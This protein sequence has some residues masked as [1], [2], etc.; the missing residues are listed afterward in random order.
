MGA[1]QFVTSDEENIPRRSITF[2][3]DDDGAHWQRLEPLDGLSLSLAGSLVVGSL[4]R[5][6][7]VTARLASGPLR[8]VM[9]PA[10][11]CN[12]PTAAHLGRE[13]ALDGRRWIGWQD[14]KAYEG[15]DL[16]TRDC[17]D[18]TLAE[19][20]TLWETD[21]TGRRAARRRAVFRECSGPGPVGASPRGGIVVATCF[22]KATQES[23]VLASRH[24]GEAFR[25]EAQ[26]HGM[27]GS[28]LPG[29]VPSRVR[30]ASDGAV[31]VLGATL[32]SDSPGR[33]D[34]WVLGTPNGRYTEVTMENA[35][36]GLTVRDV[37][38]T[39]RGIVAIAGIDKSRTS[40][41]RV[42]SNGG[43]TWTRPQGVP[44]DL[45]LSAVAGERDDVAVFG[46]RPHKW[47]VG[48]PPDPPEYPEG[49]LATVV[50]IS[51]DGGT[52]WHEEDAPQERNGTLAS[53]AISLFGRRG[54][55]LTSE[56]IFETTDAAHTWSRLVGSP[57]LRPLPF[58]CGRSGCRMS[59][60]LA[61]VW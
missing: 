55:A 2:G 48:G 10:P 12:E 26:L 13:G 50:L 17:P 32:S 58:V 28:E 8:W 60:T 27:S 16:R 47:L 49:P 25:E 21:L 31:A 22:V 51:S 33:S 30:V 54:L 59:E 7:E 42:S 4:E 44:S 41:L 9:E 45:D 46:Y 57:S 39:S 34:H 61:R 18:G 3:T 35:D 23:L 40:E 52:T 5:A 14:M 38:F 43:R 11:S 20:P 15:R 36:S 24:D 37:A 29:L 1:A 19:E 56:G 53:Q 6:D